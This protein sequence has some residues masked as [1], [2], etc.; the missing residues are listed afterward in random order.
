MYKRQVCK[1]DFGNDFAM[2]REEAIKTL[3]EQKYFGWGAVATFYKK[4]IDVYKRQA[5]GSISE[6][7]APGALSDKHTLSGQ[8]T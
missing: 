5:S 1:Y 7:K 3:I 6:G 8:P 4:D 2:D